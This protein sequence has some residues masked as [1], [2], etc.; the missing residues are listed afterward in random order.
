[1][2]SPWSACSISRTRLSA[3]SSDDFGLVARG[4]F[5]QE[6]QRPKAPAP[7]CDGIDADCWVGHHLDPGLVE[8]DTGERGH[9]SRIGVLRVVTGGF[10]GTA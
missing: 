10:P 9:Y 5:R 7:R 6:F 4:V 1:M 2:E 3:V 8:A